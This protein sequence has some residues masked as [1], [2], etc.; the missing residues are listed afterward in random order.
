MAIAST[1]WAPPVVSS[2][3][4]A[5]GELRWDTDYASDYG[6]TIPI[7]GTTGAPIVDEGLLI[8]IVGGAPDAI[9]VG[10]D[11]LTGEEVWRAVETVGDMGYSQPVIYTA[12]GVR[13]LIV[14]HATALGS[15]QK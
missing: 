10:F 12:G 9:V 7:W 8:A 4:I 15:A 1:C 2:V 14:S 13:Q 3:S 11:K 5:A 6:T